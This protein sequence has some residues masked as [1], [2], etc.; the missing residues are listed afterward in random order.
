[1]NK[2][3]IFYRGKRIIIDFEIALLDNKK[4]TNNKNY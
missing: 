4:L 2:L 3:K 1:M